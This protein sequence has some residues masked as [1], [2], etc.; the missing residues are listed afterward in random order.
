[1]YFISTRLIYWMTKNTEQMDSNVCINK[2]I[3]TV[4]SKWQRGYKSVQYGGKKHEYD[5]HVIYDID[6]I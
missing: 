2:P 5:R 6:P 3:D 4:N 1:M